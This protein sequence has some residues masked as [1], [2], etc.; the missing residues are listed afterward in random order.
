MSHIYECELYKMD[1]QPTIPYEKIFNGN[2][3]RQITVYKKF[4]QNMIKREAMEEISDP[5]D[6]LDP[7]YICSKG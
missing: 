1:E 3:N 7:L 6:H 4:K 2:L 5:C